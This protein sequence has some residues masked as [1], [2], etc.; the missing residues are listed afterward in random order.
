MAKK[1][2]ADR[3]KHRH[4]APSKRRSSRPSSG[5]GKGGGA[6]SGLRAGFRGLLGTGGKRKSGDTSFWSVM[7][8]LVLVFAVA[9]L[10]G[11]YAC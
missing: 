7:I 10:F 2:V 9:V 1:K 5:G 8:I 4:R 11:R 6:M 3:Q